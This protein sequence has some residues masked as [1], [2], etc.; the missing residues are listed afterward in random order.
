MTPRPPASDDHEPFDE[1]AVGWALHALEPEDE[2]AFAVH[3]PTCDRCTAT[4]AETTEVM[5]ALAAD[6]P[7]AEPSEQVRS[8]LRTAVEHTPQL[9]AVP[10]PTRPPA[11]APASQPSAPAAAPLPRWRRMLPAALV[12]AAVATIVGLGSWAVGLNSEREEL[13]STVAAQ[14]AV[15]ENL[16]RQGR[17][18]VAPLT[19]DGRQVATVV[20]REGE[21]TVVTQQL[22]ANDSSETTYVVWGLEGEEATALGVFDVDGSQMELKTV[23]S[24]LTGLDEY[25]V[26]GISLEPG[27]EAPSEP[28]DVVATGQVTS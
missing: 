27:R 24:G 18:T 14:G 9:P 26:Y 16:L 20:A 21:V 11:A 25:P 3:L 5:A 22:E 28:T 23:G 10:E 2:A 4:V 12:A 6:L 1:L 8:R 13:R 17:A 7:R 15:V 19:A